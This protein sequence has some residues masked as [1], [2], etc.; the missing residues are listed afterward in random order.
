MS[1]NNLVI[2]NMFGETYSLRVITAYLKSKNIP[3]EYSSANVGDALHEHGCRIDLGGDLK[4]STQ[5]HPMIAGSAFAETAIQNTRLRK[6]VYN[7]FGYQDD[8]MRHKTPERLFAHIEK[9]LASI[10]EGAS[11]DESLPDVAEG[12]GETA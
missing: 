4:M 9:V 3:F 6:L 2:L 12:F 8:V 5:T 10:L 1:H 7:S 11:A